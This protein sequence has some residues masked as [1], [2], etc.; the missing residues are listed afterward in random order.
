MSHYNLGLILK[1]EFNDLPLEVLPE[2]SKNTHNL[3]VVLRWLDHC[4]MGK[5][6]L[7]ILKS[8]QTVLC[9]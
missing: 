8:I 2:A 6:V 4:M 9:D 7:L 5:E 3:V 1:I